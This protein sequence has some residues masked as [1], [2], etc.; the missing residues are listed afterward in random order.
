[1]ERAIQFTACAEMP[2][3]KVAHSNGRYAMEADEH[4]HD[5]HG[6]DTEGIRGILEEI[7][8]GDTSH[9][10]GLEA[11]RGLVGSE[12][13]GHDDHGEHGD[14]DEHDHGIFD[15]HVWLDPVLAV[16]QIYNIRDALV[17]ADPDNAQTY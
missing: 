13:H 2:D 3:E 11:I 6:H 5:D 9:I 17:E 10:E 1:M 7:R 16:R 4:G 12:G 15:P 14:H 8:D